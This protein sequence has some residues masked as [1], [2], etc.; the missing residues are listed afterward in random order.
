GGKSAAGALFK[1][2]DPVVWRSKDAD[3]MA[4][5]KAGSLLLPILL[6]F[7]VNDCQKT[8]SRSWHQAV[9]FRAKAVEFCFDSVVHRCAI[10]PLRSKLDRGTGG[11]SL[12]QANR[13]GSKGSFNAHRRIRP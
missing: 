11:L 5:Q 4:A 2:S 12:V 13:I 8:L 1:V 3:Q 6:R 7:S 9:D 10:R